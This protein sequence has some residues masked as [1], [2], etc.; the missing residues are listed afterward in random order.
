MPDVF[1]SRDSKKKEGKPST[2]ET[3]EEVSKLD[4]GKENEVNEKGPSKLHIGHKKG[5][6]KYPKNHKDRLELPGHTHNPLTSFSYFPDKVKFVNQDPEERVI[7]LL[8][9]H[10]ITNIRWIL[11]TPFL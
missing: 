1:I 9:K 5:G 6:V 2:Y 8:R 11:L 10:P 7:L 3:K 4:S